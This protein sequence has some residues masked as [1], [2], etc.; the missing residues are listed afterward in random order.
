[1]DDAFRMRRIN[2]IGNLPADD[3]CLTRYDRA[4]S[5]SLRKRFALYE[6]EYERRKPAGSF[7]AVNGADVRVI[8]G[9]KHP[10]FA[11]E[12]SQPLLV[13]DKH[14]RQHLDRHVS[15]ELHVVCAV[16]L[17]HTAAANER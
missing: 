10:R 7:D 11:V 5:Q 9:G 8:E 12:P 2:C 16:H 17:A 13:A 15:T 3:Q 1:M 4:S 14:R 6:L